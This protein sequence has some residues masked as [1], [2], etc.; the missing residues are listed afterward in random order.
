[1]RFKEYRQKAGLTVAEVAQEMGITDVAIYLWETGRCYPRPAL[2]TKLAK[3]YG[4]TVDELLSEKE[5]A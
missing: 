4:C 2:L 3:L 5:G 1:M